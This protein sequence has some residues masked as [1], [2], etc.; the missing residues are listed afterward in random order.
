MILLWVV[1]VGVLKKEPWFIWK[2][3]IIAEAQQN[4][5]VNQSYPLYPLPLGQGV[6]F[7]VCQ[8]NLFDVE[9]HAICHQEKTKRVKSIL[10]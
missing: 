9:Y 2:K 8:N 10:S 4:C 3:K 7:R 1:Q 5:I 6:H